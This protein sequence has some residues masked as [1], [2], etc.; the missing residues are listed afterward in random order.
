MRWDVINHIARIVEARTYLEIG[1]SSGESMRH[2][3]ID[4]K[5]G[6]DPEPQLEGVRS[7]D[8]FMP[9]NSDDAFAKMDPSSDFF[10]IVFIDGF[11]HAD[12]AYR[13]IMNAV[14]VSGIVVVHDSNPS[15][16]EMQRVPQVSGEWTGDV[17]KAIARIRT[18][19]V[20]L[21]RTID[22]DYGVAVII[23]NRGED[24]PELPR[25]TWGDLQTNRQELLGLIQVYEWKAWFN[26]AFDEI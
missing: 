17:W 20:H 5:V 1:V 2:V 14:L 8:I 19:G 16:E 9:K 6:V 11:H 18:E 24:V 4:T 7:C 23:P 26:N 3:D 22:T 13:D 12:Q 25:E 10:D 21:V 15:T